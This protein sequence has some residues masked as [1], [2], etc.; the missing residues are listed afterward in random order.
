MGF[1][2]GRVPGLIRQPSGAGAD[3]PLSIANPCDKSRTILPDRDSGRGW[4]AA[5]RLAKNLARNLAKNLFCIFPEI[6]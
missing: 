1:P 6:E 5:M 4:I 3:S 2:G